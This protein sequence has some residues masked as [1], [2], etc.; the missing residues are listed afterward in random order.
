MPG[1]LHRLGNLGEAVAGQI[2]QVETAGQIE[3]IDLSRMA[4]PRGHAGE[5]AAAGQRVDQTRLADIGTAGEGY[6]RQRDRRQR[7][8]R[9]GTRDEVAGAGKELARR[10]N[11]LGRA[12]FRRPPLWS[13]G[14]HQPF[15]PEPLLPFLDAPPLPAT[16]TGAGLAGG[17]ALP[18]PIGV[19]WRR[20]IVYCCAIESVLLQAQ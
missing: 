5:R 6:F 20:M 18:P 11:L 19:P 12:P 13:I 2:D 8:D 4:G 15:L 17:L 10:L 14:C 3:E 9:A 16:G 7:L 1:L